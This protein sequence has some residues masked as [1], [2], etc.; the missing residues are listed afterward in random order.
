MNKIMKYKIIKP[1]DATWKEFGDI[2][3]N[4]Q[5]D[6]REIMN[7]TLQLCWEYQGYS[8]DY[9]EKNDIYPNIKETLGYSNLMGYCYDQLK[10]K[11]NKFNSGNYTTSLKSVTDKWKS[12]LK[13]ILKGDVSIP[14]YKKDIPIDIH[15]NSINIIKSNCD[16]FA[17]LS[18]ISNTYK[19]ELNRKSGQ[20]M[21]LIKVGD[22]TQKVILDRI[23]SGEYKISASKIIKHKTK[24]EWYIYVCYGFEPKQCFLDKNNVMGVDMG[25][26]YP[27]YIAFNN[28]LNRYKIEGGE[29]EQFRKQTEKRKNSLYSQG[30]FCSNGRIGHG[31]KSRIKPIDFSK[32]KVSNFRDTTNHKYS[33]YVIDMAIKNNC[34]IIQMEDLSGITK[35]KENKFLKN[36]SYYDLQQKIEYKAKEKGIEVIYINPYKTS[37]RCSKCGYI[38][39]NNRPKD[40]RGQSYFKCITCG[41]E[42]NADFNAARNIATQ[43]IDLIIA[44]NIKKLQ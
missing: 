41:F 39:T 40:E 37:Q 8:A 18:L 30:K 32:N 19:K 29:I 28:S 14:S 9:K 15:N 34:G 23:L 10:Y 27:V 42:T 6:T 16:Y 31:I 1:I 13:N 4:L 35:D 25:I 21:V 7:K 26:V 2:L 12:D 33:K 44:E 24:Q 22:N 20:F 36:W 17:N 5:R 38:D 11:Y 3:Y 43:N